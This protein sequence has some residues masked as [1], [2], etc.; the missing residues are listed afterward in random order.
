MSMCCDHARPSS[1]HARA[2]A[3]LMTAMITVARSRSCPVRSF[4]PLSSPGPSDE[5]KLNFYW[6]P[7]MTNRASLQQ[8][9][10]QPSCTPDRQASPTVRSVPKQGR[11]ARKRH[12]LW[13]YGLLA[14]RVP[15][16]RAR[17]LNCQPRPRTDRDI[18]VAA[19]SS[20]GWSAVASLSTRTV[21]AR[22]PRIFAVAGFTRHWR[23]VR[24]ARSGR[25]R[26]GSKAATPLNSR[27]AAGAAAPR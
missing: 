26:P 15:G 20:R 16:H 17:S 6:G 12:A 25:P 2:R 22:P 7:F 5:H 14:V 27:R 19:N 11:S 9:V 21:P 10:G 23:E 18:S 4:M 1:S 13:D 24:R 8:T 3:D